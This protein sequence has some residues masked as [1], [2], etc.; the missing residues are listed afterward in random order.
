[1]LS[2]K[3]MVPGFEPILGTTDVVLSEELV[4]NHQ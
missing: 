1:M 4:R 3:Y 2:D